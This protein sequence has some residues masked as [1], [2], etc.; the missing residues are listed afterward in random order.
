MQ[1]QEFVLR[2]LGIYTK[3]YFTIV[4]CF[5]VY[6]KENLRNNPLVELLNTGKV[7]YPKIK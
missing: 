7:N 4:S 2:M 1:L 3:I 6:S 5:F